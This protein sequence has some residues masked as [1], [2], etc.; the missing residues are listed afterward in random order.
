NMN[1]EIQNRN[2]LLIE[3]QLSS[4]LVGIY[5]NN[6]LLL[7]N[8]FQQ[9]EPLYKKIRQNFQERFEKLIESTNELIKTNEFDKIADSILQI[10]KCIPTLNKH[11]NNVVEDKY[12]YVVQSL[13]QYLSNFQEKSELILAKPRL[14]ESEIN[15]VKNA[16]TVLG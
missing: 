14:N 10:S 5:L 6:V 9:I 1:S 3:E 4:S 8:S 15:I 16:V 11:L 12:K 7:K 2:K 13:L